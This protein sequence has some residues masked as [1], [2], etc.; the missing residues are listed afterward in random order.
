[1]I[2]IQRSSVLLLLFTAACIPRKQPGSSAGAENTVEGKKCGPDGVIDDGEDNNNQSAATK[3]RG[4]Y[5]YTFAD[6]SSAI[7]PTAGKKGGVFNM[8]QGGANG[9]QYGAHMNGKVG[10]GNIV[11]AGMGLNFTEPKGPYDASAYKGISFWA[12]KGS[13]GTAKVRLKVPDKNTDPDGKVCAECFNDFGSDLVLT[14]QWTKYVVPFNQMKQLGGWG[15]PHPPAIDPKTIYGVQ[16]QVN[17][18]GASYDIWID[19]VEFT[20]CP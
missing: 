9:S 10:G 11:F 13:A 12:K 1:M 20:G 15:S 7:T 6:D 8:S 17:E 3:G 19:D 14:E 18:P 16:F 4:G 2:S 5:W